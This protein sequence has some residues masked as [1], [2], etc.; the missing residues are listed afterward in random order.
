MSCMVVKEVFYGCWL[1]FL[2]VIALWALISW[3]WGIVEKWGE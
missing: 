1:W 2:S 3:I